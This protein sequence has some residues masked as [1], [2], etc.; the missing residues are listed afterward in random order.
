MILKIA[1]AVVYNQVK[2]RLHLIKVGLKSNMTDILIRGKKFG[3]KYSE[4][5]VI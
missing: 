2:V 5:K 3:N 4:R 1:F